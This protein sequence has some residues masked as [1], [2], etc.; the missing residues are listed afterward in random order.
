[1]ETKKRF[2]NWLMAF[3]L[4]AMIASLLGSL[5]AG[6]AAQAKSIEPLALPAANRPSNVQG[7]VVDKPVYPTV[8]DIDV[9][10]LPQAGPDPKSAPLFRRPLSRPN[11]APASQLRLI[12]PLVQTQAAVSDMPSPISVF[13]GLDRNNWGNGWP[14]DTNGDVGPTYY[15]QGLP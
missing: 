2:S 14:P 1:M 15:I 13:P 12:D 6:P 4:I 9:R 11:P 5:H 8:R 3:G 7:P 10:T